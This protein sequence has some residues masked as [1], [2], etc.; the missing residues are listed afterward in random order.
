MLILKRY[1]LCSKCR[2]AHC[3]CSRAETFTVDSGKF[4]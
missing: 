2:N 3:I 1:R 4:L